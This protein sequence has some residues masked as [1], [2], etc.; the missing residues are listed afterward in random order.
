MTSAQQAP[1]PVVDRRAPRP[2]V[3][4]R[5]PWWRS[6]ASALLWTVVVVGVLAFVVS[7]A[8]PLWF[9]AQGQ[10]LLIV[11]SGSMAPQFVAG[12]VVV[13]RAV[14]DPSELKPDLV[15]TF[16]PVGEPN[17]V[18]HRIVSLHSLPAMQDVGDGSGRMEPV[19]QEDGDPVMQPYIRTQGDAN[20][21]PDPN[22]TPVERVR[23][24][25][26]EV[27]HGWGAVLSWATSAQ[28]R[29]VMLVPPLLALATLEVVSVLEG[30]RRGR[31]ARRSRDDRRIDALVSE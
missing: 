11:T 21:E 29:A 25:V 26:L 3:R 17:L 30:R 7:L 18:T 8:A 23:G 22:A 10:R 4:P 20:P 14:T 9:Q 16:Q 19:L 1:R 27:H 6:A 2:A 5:T 15:V 13:L 28:G 31:L 24:V 12:D